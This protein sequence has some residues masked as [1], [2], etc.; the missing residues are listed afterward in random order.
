MDL[1]RE[2]HREDL[3]WFLQHRDIKVRRELHSKVDCSLVRVT[4]GAYVVNK[5]VKA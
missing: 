1:Y 4:Q 2:P 3:C 5:V